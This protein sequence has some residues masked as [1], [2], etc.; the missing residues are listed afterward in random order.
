[1]EDE[2]AK[3]EPRKLFT[4]AVRDVDIRDV[5]L[6]FGKR[7]DLNIIF[8]PDVKGTVT[9]DLKRVTLE[10]ALSAVVSPLAELSGFA[11]LFGLSSGVTDWFLCARGPQIAQNSL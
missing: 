11:L 3:G 1:M 4:L 2:T 7:T 5:L 8:G 9:A 10:E 6:T